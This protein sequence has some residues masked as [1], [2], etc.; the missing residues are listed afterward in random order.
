MAD[1][2]QDTNAAA[3]EGTGNDAFLEGLGEE[4]PAAPESGQTE[5]A[6]AAGEDSRPERAVETGEASADSAGD[7]H[8]EPEPPETVPLKFLGREY[9][10]PAQAAADIASAMGADRETL[11]QYI[12]K[13]LN[14]EKVRD[15]ARKEF[16]SREDVAIL[17]EYARA[18]GMTA[19]E[20]L[21]VL[22]QNMEQSQTR[23]AVETLKQ[24]YPEAPEDALSELAQSQREAEQLKNA[25]RMRQEAERQQELQRTEQ[26]RPWE[27]FFVRHTEYAGADDVPQEIYALVREKGLTPNEAY[28]QMQM[29]RKE[30]AHAAFVRETNKKLDAMEQ[31]LKNAQG[32]PGS[33]VSDGGEGETDAFLSGLFS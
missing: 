28:L 27:E 2:M 31:N 19:K 14:Y 26:T 5:P 23:Q 15:D 22:R 18:S 1:T 3:E 32:S 24:Q 17:R 21:D 9:A 30:E 16:E 10:I 20:Y 6:A 25:E 7:T 12:Q 29:D 13:G 11:I 33:A 8:P 4:T